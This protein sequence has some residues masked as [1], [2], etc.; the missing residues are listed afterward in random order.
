[1]TYLVSPHDLKVFFREK[2]STEDILHDLGNI[3]NNSIILGEVN[4]LV[5]LIQAQ[6]LGMRYVLLLTLNAVHWSINAT[7][8]PLLEDTL[9]EWG[10]LQVMTQVI[11]QEVISGRPSFTSHRK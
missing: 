9:K 11:G 6:Q 3:S 7:I 8:I 4:N 1:M 2:T 5:K 10:F